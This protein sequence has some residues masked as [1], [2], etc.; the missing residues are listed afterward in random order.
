MKENTLIL[1]E[2]QKKRVCKFYEC[3]D[4]DDY[5]WPDCQGILSNRCPLERIQTLFG[6]LNEERQK[7]E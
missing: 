6:F 2:Y 5:Q 3:S 7:G 1:F 4:S